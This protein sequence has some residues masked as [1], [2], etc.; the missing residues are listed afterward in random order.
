MY[1]GDKMESTTEKQ[2][3]AMIYV[4]YTVATVMLTIYGGQV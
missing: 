2:P 1:T 3:I 4:Y